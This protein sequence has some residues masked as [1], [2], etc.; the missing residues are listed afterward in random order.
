MNLY[1]VNRQRSTKTWQEFNDKSQHKHSNYD[2]LLKKDRQSVFLPF[3]SNFYNSIQSCKV[4]LTLVRVSPPVFRNW[5]LEIESLIYS[6]SKE[7]TT[8]F[9]DSAYAGTRGSQMLQCCLMMCFASVR[10]HTSG[11]QP[12]TRPGVAVLPRGGC[13]AH[14]DEPWGGCTDP[15]WQDP[16]WLHCQWWQRP[17]WQSVH[18]HLGT[19]CVCFPSGAFSDYENR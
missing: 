18:L 1:G 15:R 6:F 13:T 10:A 16:G 5:W 8:L 17:H 9:V 19:P 4:R 7:K 14:D 11:K 12:P 2:Y 3:K